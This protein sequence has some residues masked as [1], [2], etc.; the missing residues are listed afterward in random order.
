MADE[1]C[2]G[3]PDWR[4]SD[5]DRQRSAAGREA[6]AAQRGPSDDPRAGNSD[7]AG[8]G[9][10]GRVAGLE[11]RSGI[12]HSIK[13]DRAG[14]GDAHA[15]HSLQ[16]TG[17]DRGDTRVAIRTT[18]VENP[19]TA[20]RLGDAQRGR[21]GIVDQVDAHRVV[22]GRVAAKG[23]R[24]RARA[25]INDVARVAEHEGRI[26]LR[27]AGEDAVAI[28]AVALDRGAAREGEETIGGDGRS[29]RGLVDRRG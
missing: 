6:A 10:G 25:G 22:A 28:L 13:E 15:I 17:I 9:R 2:R 21:A 11:D 23:Q 26:V 12:E 29:L 5:V 19:Q 27:A 8:E 1:I 20:V 18:R 7:G 24:T 16:G 14:R 3:A 4:A